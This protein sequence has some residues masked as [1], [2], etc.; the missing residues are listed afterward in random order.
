MRS[1]WVGV[2]KRQGE[3]SAKLL[4]QVDADGR[5]VREGTKAV[6]RR[7]CGMRARIRSGRWRRC[8]RECTLQVTLAG[9]AGRGGRRGKR[10]GVCE[11]KRVHVNEILP[12]GGAKV[13][14]REKGK[15]GR[16]V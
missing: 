10:G 12:V 13:F 1:V 4:L 9:R 15:L 8:E 7:Y 3:G 16:D 2:Q 11:E 5:Q 14:M 6:R